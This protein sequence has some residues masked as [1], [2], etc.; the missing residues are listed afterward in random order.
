MERPVSENGPLKLGRASQG[1]EDL[2][3]CGL[4]LQVFGHPYGGWERGSPGPQGWGIL[5]ES[6]EATEVGFQVHSFRHK[7]P[8]PNPAVHLLKDG[9]G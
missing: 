2:V 8:D 7:D 1:S 6:S 9:D 4:H 3:R 5:A